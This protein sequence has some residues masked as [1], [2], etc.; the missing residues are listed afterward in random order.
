ML[1]KK[2]GFGPGFMADE[3]KVALVKRIFCL[4]EPFFSTSGY[5]L[6]LLD[7]SDSKPTRDPLKLLAQKLAKII[8]EENLY[9]IASHSMCNAMV[10]SL[11]PRLNDFSGPIILLE[12]PNTASKFQI[13]RWALHGGRRPFK[14]P[15]E[16]DM[17]KNSA[18][19]S[20]LT[21]TSLGSIKPLEIGGRLS[22]HWYT[23][24]AFQALPYTAYVQFPSASH[25]KMTYDPAI[26][27]LVIKYLDNPQSVIS[28][29]ERNKIDRIP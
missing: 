10:R 13:A 14:Y 6:V 1:K 8:D 28:F 17:P 15:C 26:L 25:L 7:Y 3:K 22:A 9:A 11:A 12:G 2:V 5:K 20:S 18:F 4:V 29:V 24:S 16:Q 27:S 21:E 19:M 23:K